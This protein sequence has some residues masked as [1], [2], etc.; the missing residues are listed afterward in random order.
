MRDYNTSQPI[1]YAI[2][3]LVVTTVLAAQAKAGDLNV[4]RSRAQ[5]ADQ[6][7]TFDEWTIPGLG[8]QLSTRTLTLGCQR[9][10]GVVPGVGET[11]SKRR[12]NGSPQVRKD[13][14]RFGG[15]E[16]TRFVC[17]TFTPARPESLLAASPKSLWLVPQ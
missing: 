5:R 13:V 3:A 4:Y 6:S 2:I 9:K 12:E 10:Y 17:T 16:E 7:M 14:G 15:H 11:G 1:G 8:F